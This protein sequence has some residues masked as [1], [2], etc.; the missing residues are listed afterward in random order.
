MKRIKEID[1]NM[2]NPL[3]WNNIIVENKPMKNNENTNKNKGLKNIKSS[4]NLQIIGMPYESIK[5]NKPVPFVKT[6][7]INIKNYKDDYH[8][9]NNNINNKIS[10][11][12]VKGSIMIILGLYLKNFGSQILQKKMV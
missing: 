11:I 8:Y 5:L 1:P 3:N 9:S 10:E 7:I 4:K 12:I 6:H 2:D